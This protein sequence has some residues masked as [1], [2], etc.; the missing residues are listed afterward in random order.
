MKLKSVRVEGWCKDSREG[1]SKEVLARW[2]RLGSFADVLQCL[3]LDTLLLQKQNTNK[4]YGTKNNCVHE[5]LGQILD[6]NIKRLKFPTAI[7]KSLEQTQGAMHAPC[8][9]HHLSHTLANPL[10]TPTFTLIRNK[11]SSPQG[12]E[13]ARGICYLF[14]LP[15]AAAGP[16]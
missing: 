9:Q 16:Q 1:I 2:D 12:K 3:H 5:Q 8:T 7:L 15:T 11:L 10:D 4:W 14:S 6:K 13:P